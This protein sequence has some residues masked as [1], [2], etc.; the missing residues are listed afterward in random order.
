MAFEISVSG[1]S[2]CPMSV[3]WDDNRGRLLVCDHPLSRMRAAPSVVQDR[4]VDQRSMVT[5]PEWCPL[6]VEQALVT[7][8]VK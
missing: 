6:R 4:N 2:D 8:R 3:A 1:C 5:A 7:L